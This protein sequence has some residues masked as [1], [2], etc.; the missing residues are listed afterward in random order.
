M[1]QKYE[2]KNVQAF[3]QEEL[4]NGVWIVL[5]KVKRIPPHLALLVNGKYFSL[6]VNGL[7][8]NLDALN[9]F[10]I[11]VQKKANDVFIKIKGENADVI[12]ADTCYSNDLHLNDGSLTC[13]VPLK[14]FLEKYTGISLV[15]ANYIFEVIKTN[16]IE[17]EKV[18]QLNADALMEGNSLFL[19]AYTMEEIRNC[20]GKLNARKL[21]TSV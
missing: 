1:K 11:S 12:L 10:N 8:K 6:S 16:G 15:N 17:I 21:A 14:L 4:L 3:V 7:E 20:I 5:H 13:L 19:P 18:M 9:V 2:L